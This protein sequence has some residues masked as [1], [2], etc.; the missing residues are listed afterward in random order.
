MDRVHPLTDDRVPIKLV[1]SPR[2]VKP[3]TPSW[4]YHLD[5]GFGGGYDSVYR[6]PAI[7][8]GHDNDYLCSQRSWATIIPS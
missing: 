5:E 3:G 6:V 8:T 4:S 2:H 7:P 1:N